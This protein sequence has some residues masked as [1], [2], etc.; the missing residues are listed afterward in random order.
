MSFCASSS[1]V[2]IIFVAI[3]FRVRGL[4]LGLRL[5]VV[6]MSGEGSTTRADDGAEDALFSWRHTMST[7]H[8]PVDL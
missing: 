8:E 3:C 2:R 5:F 1:A 7:L 4:R 6:V